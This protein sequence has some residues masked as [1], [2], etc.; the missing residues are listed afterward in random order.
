MLTA[1]HRLEQDLLV[2]TNTYETVK[3]SAELVGL[4][5][6][7]RHLLDKLLNLQVPALRTFENLEMKREFEKLT[8]QL[9]EGRDR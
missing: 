8:L 5:T 6:A 9:R 4:V 3:L 2:A 7:T 1:R